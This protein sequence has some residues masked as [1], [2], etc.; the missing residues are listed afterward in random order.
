MTPWFTEAGY[1]YYR[2]DLLKAA[3]LPVPKT[4][5]E[6][7]AT[8]AKLQA[9]K[10]AKYGFVFQGATT[11]ELT[12]NWVEYLNDAGGQVV[13]NDY[14]KGTM[15]TPQGVKALTFM[16]S[17]VT[18]G[19]TP[20]AVTT[21]QSAESLSAFNSG[22][23]VF[24][25]NWGYAYAI[26]Q[27]KKSSSV[28]GKVGMAPLP[29]FAGAKGPGASVVGGGN[30]YINPHSGHLKESLEFL[31]W[32]GTTEAQKILANVGEVLPTTTEVAKDPEVQKINTPMS[33]LPDLRLVSRQVATPKYPGLTKAVFRAVNSALA[34]DTSVQSALAGADK[35]IDA[36][37]KGSL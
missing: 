10:K 2:K 25:R 14:S 16:R 5:E 37:L 8:A 29:T 11:E 3:G 19:V 31:Q 7:A 30:M 26:T 9:A 36:A 23:S 13:D 4:W 35:E 32:M 1:L 21:F 15:D 34:G 33:V 27:D 12:C 20:K 24:M 28:V 22:Q 18:S 6:L 17:L